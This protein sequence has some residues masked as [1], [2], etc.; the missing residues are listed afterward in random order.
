M[1]PGPSALSTARG[2]KPF[3]Q[4]TLE[5]EEHGRGGHVAVG[6]EHLALMVERALREGKRALERGDHLGAARVADETVDIGKREALP[7][8]HVIHR[9]ARNW[10]R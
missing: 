1:K 6:G 3:F 7:F 8:E 2:G 9:D 5:H 10:P 4:D